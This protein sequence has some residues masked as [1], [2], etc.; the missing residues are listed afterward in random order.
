[1]VW[2]N[3]NKSV[4]RLVVYSFLFLLCLFYFKNEFKRWNRTERNIL[5]TIIALYKQGVF[6]LNDKQVK[7]NKMH[8]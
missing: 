2:T 3:T 8:Y 5:P 1:M 6:F 7:T 4:V